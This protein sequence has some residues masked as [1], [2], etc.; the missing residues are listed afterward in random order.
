MVPP[1]PPSLCGFWPRFAVG[2]WLYSGAIS[3]AGGDDHSIPSANRW[4]DRA[5]S[6]TTTM[7]IH[8]HNKPHSLT[9]VGW[10]YPWYHN[11]CQS[12]APVFKAGDRVWLD[13]SNIHTTHPS[14]KLTH[15]CLGP[16]RVKKVV[17]HGLYCLC[18]PLALLPAP[19]IPSCKA[20]PPPCFID[21]QGGVCGRGDI[22][23]SWIWC[24]TWNI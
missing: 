16:Y 24:D 13:A 5:S 9:P 7:F 20:A 1:W 17:G 19:C 3:P 8:R 22:L 12:P 18:L 23:D 15:H 10:A 14:A 6:P 11:H 4:P 2:G 21:E